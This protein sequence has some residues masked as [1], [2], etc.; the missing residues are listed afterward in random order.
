MWNVPAS[1][2]VPQAQNRAAFHGPSSSPHVSH[3]FR[4][5]YFRSGKFTM[6]LTHSRARSPSHQ[7][8]WRRKGPDSPFK[9][10]PQSSQWPSPEVVLLR[11]WRHRLT[12]A[13]APHA[14]GTAS[15]DGQQPP[16]RSG[17]T[18]HGW[19]S[20]LLS[21][22]RAKGKT[23]PGSGGDCRVGLTGDLGLLWL[24]GTEDPR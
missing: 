21:G 12:S 13:F 1:F 3:G 11:A 4:D 15:V 14:D 2:P 6:P 17:C 5:R 7:S 23:R 10:Q 20:G 24:V 9:R 8:S 22:D 19:D 18:R 16:L